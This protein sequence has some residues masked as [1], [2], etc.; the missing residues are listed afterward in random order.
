MH[1]KNMTE[2]G[3]IAELV[4]AVLKHPDLPR[5]LW[6]AMMEGICEVECTTEMYEN[7]EVLREVFGL[8]ATPKEAR[9]AAT[10]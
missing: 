6:E 4:V 7:P 1:E 3:D 9:R 10:K 2:H 5:E 8:N